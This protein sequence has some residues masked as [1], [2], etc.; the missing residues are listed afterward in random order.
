MGNFQII[1]YFAY[2][3]NL[4]YTS[5]MRFLGIDYGSKRV[6]IALSD[7]K[8]QFAIPFIT[9]KTSKSLVQEIIDIAHENSVE[10]IVMGESRDYDGK[11]NKIYEESMNVKKQ[12]EEKGYAVILEP[13]FMTS[14]HAEKFQGKHDKID[15]SAAAL[16]LQSY[17]DTHPQ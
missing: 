7:E 16:I 17:L 10:A 12:L 4:E 8:G 1:S 9:L 5:L 13:E 14:A 11:P 2:I 15:A 3:F 6:G